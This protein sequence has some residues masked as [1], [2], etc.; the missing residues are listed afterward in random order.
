MLSGGRSFKEVNLRA[1]A[2]EKSSRSKS[3]YFFSRQT[4]NCTRSPQL[5][6]VSLLNSMTLPD[7]K[8]ERRQNSNG[9]EGCVIL[10]DR[11][12]GL[13][14]GVR[15]LLE[16][17]FNTVVMVAD[18]RSLLETASRISPKL[19]VVDLSLS[20]ADS[21]EWLGRLRKSCPD[22]KL[23]VISVHDEPSVAKKAIESGAH[24][25]VLKRAIA[26]DLLAA[27]DSVLAGQQYLPEMSNSARSTTKPL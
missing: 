11:H 24:G 27:V 25:V 14:E 23:I 20:R 3:Q 18:E 6:G 8:Q 1:I 5:P 19:A 26:T 15:S 2:A 16:T 10:A 7:G 9:A 12:H 22:M 13:I 17:I 21:I 4:S